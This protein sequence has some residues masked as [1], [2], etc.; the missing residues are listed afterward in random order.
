M[1]LYIWL[2]TRKEDVKNYNDSLKTNQIQINWQRQTTV[3]QDYIIKPSSHLRR[4]QH[5]KVNYL[6]KI[7]VVVLRTQF[8][9]FTRKIIFN[10]HHCE[11]IMYLRIWADG[12]VNT[13]ILSFVVPFFFYWRGAFLPRLYYKL[14]SL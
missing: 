4:T 14:Y 12:D 1:Y 9:I 3:L 6:I 5:S 11:V 2:C 8:R 13:M 10:I 7:L